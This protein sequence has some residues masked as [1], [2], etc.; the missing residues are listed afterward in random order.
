[1]KETLR[2][3]AGKSPHLLGG[4]QFL[5][6]S[7]GEIASFRDL[8][9]Q[10][11]LA[12]H[13]NP[14][15]EKPFILPKERFGGTEDVLLIP[16]MRN[17]VDQT[18][19]DHAYSSSCLLEYVGKTPISPH[20]SMG[21][22]VSR[23]GYVDW[24]YV[25]DLDFRIFLPPQLGHLSGFKTDL[26]KTLTSELQKYDLYRVPLGK[27]E[28]GLPQVQL[29][30]LRTGGIHGFH[31]FLIGMKPEFAKANLHRD[32]GYSPHH[33]YFPETSMDEPL[34]A[35]GMQWCDVIQRQGEDY[36]DMFD[37][38]SFN[39]FGD[40]AGK[41]GKL[42][43]PGWYLR[44][45]FKWYATLAR[46]RGFLSLEEDLIYQ[47]EHFQRSEAEFSYLARYR[48]YARMAPKQPPLKDLDRDL[49]RV[50]SL[51]YAQA[52]NPLDSLVGQQIGDD[53][54]GIV[55]LE[56][57]P[58]DLTVAAW[59]LLKQ[60]GVPLPNQV[61]D[62]SFAARTRFAD[63]LTTP[64][65]VYL[66]DGR[67]AVLIPSE[68]SMV[69][70]DFYFRQVMKKVVEEKQTFV[71]KDIRQAAVALLACLLHQAFVS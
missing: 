9:I 23:W 4:L 58:E 16:L 33:L 25:R 65:R 5:F 18:L 62:P 56:A 34:K 12:S 11:V 71:Q 7:G 28:R 46:M 22:S 35:V 67:D 6:R 3:L 24:D 48:Y 44:K 66:H 20:G 19:R 59:K 57:V 70:S 38:L 42:K 15:S 53:T 68:W 64:C 29:R 40:D 8:R 10:P 41:S 30:D 1:V 37:Q 14:V 51:I 45:A 21:L 54:P 32:G 26:A 2:A 55:L 47:F 13:R 39:I 43:T 61:H 27:D 50:A 36:I 60:N 63:H 69:F 31:L 49:A 52:R 17:V